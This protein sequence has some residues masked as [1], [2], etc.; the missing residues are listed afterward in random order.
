MRRPG[1]YNFRTYP[2]RGQSVGSQ[3]YY[4]INLKH[5][6][7]GKERHIRGFDKD[8]VEQKARIQAQKWDEQWEKQVK[9][10]VTKAKN[11]IRQIYK[12]SKAEEAEKKTR[13]AQDTINKIENILYQ[14]LEINDTINWNNLKRED[15]FNKKPPKPAKFHPEPKITDIKYQTVDLSKTPGLLVSRPEPLENDSAFKPKL[16]FWKRMF[17]SADAKR[18]MTHDK[19]MLALKEWETEKQRIDDHNRPILDAATKAEDARIQDLF[20]SDL[21]KFKKLNQEIS[22]L[23]EKNRNQYNFELKEFYDEQSRSNAAIDTQYNN[24]IS[25]IP[26]NVSDY[27]DMVLENSIYPEFFPRDWELEYNQEGRILILD[28][29]LPSPESMPN[30]KEVKYLKT[31]DELK[32]IYLSQKESAILYDETLYRITLRTIHELFEADEAKALDAIIFNGYVNS[33]EASSGNHVTSCVLTVQASK[34]EFLAFNLRNVDPKSCFKALKGIGSSKLYGITPVPPIA[35]IN[36]EDRRFIDSH[37]NPIELDESTNLAA[38][39]WEDFE[40]LI[41]E[42]FEKEFSSGGGEVRVTQ[43]SRDGGVDAVIF[44]PDP[45]RG[46]KIVVQAKRYT[47]TV[48]VS[49]VRDLYGTMMNEG[50]MKGILVT[51]SSFGHDA[52]EFVKDK[53]LTL[54]SGANL[55]HLL[56][57]HGHSARINITEARLLQQ[58]LR[59]RTP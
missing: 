31:K 13:E 50:A 6:G 27:C 53:P 22:D 56:R 7:L 33:I 42:I 5:D 39:D 3:L 17:T 55:L 26:Q 46:G 47:N 30:L 34:E 25:G 36:R 9:S 43:A 38:M 24:Y 16:S 2:N 23:N 57:K 1:Q 28:F 37:V 49:A 41:R 8:I 19:F 32:D 40:H 44:D 10:D 58:D 12:E 21:S 18:Q 11:L 48:G 54:L 29:S 4:Y 14:T 35:R 51:T 52:Y 59:I 45:I 20:N 15:K